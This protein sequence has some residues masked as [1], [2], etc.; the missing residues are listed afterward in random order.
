MPIEVTDEMVELFRLNHD[1]ANPEEQPDIRAGLVAVLA[2]VRRDYRLSK[3]CTAELVPGLRCWRPEHT[4]GDHEGKT[5]TGNL[6]KW[7]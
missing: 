4:R 5:S 6:V 3:I 2:M 1:P 7:S